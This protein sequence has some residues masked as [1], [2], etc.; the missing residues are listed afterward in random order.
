[1][2]L[3]LVPVTATAGDLSYTC[4][5]AFSVDGARAAD[6]LCVDA[7]DDRKTWVDAIG[8]LAAG[9]GLLAIGAVVVRAW[10]DPDRD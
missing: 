3:A 6:P 8:A 9:F 10:V 4:G 5:R 1:V 7:V 2:L